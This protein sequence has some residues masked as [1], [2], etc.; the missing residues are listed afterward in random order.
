MVRRNAELRFAE[1]QSDLVAA[2]LRSV[3]RGLF[4]SAEAELLLGRIRD[5]TSVPDPAEQG[6]PG[7]D[8]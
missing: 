6:D 3:Q 5:R 1:S 2:I 7:R 8:L 4:S